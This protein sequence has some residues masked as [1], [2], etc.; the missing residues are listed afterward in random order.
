MQKNFF[1]FMIWDFFKKYKLSQKKFLNKGMRELLLIIRQMLYEFSRVV[2]AIFLGDFH[3]YFFKSRVWEAEI[4]NVATQLLMFCWQLALGV[5][6]LQYFEKVF[7]LLLLSHRHTYNN[8]TTWV[9]KY[10]CWGHQNANLL[11]QKFGVLR[12]NH[13]S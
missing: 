13:K 10:A 1:F 3:K 11:A 4:L 12:L 7:K 8:T 5:V 9:I 6:C 2:S